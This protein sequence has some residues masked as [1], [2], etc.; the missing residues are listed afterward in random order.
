[1]AFSTET[2]QKTAERPGLARPARR[3]GA[4]EHTVYQHIAFFEIPKKKLIVN[5]RVFFAKR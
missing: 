4:D 2:Q 1:M 5:A 3:P